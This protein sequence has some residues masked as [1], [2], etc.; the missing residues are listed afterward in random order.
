[1]LLKDWDRCCSTSNMQKKVVISTLTLK[2]AVMI[3]RYHHHFP[4]LGASGKDPNLAATAGCYIHIID[5]IC[6]NFRQR[7]TPL[8]C[9]R[10]HSMA[11]SRFRFFCRELVEKKSGI[12]IDLSLLIFQDIVYLNLT[13][14]VCTLLTYSF[15][16]TLFLCCYQLIRYKTKL[17]NQVS[18]VIFQKE[19]IQIWLSNFST[20]IKFLCDFCFYQFYHFDHYSER[21]MS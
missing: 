10:R 20:F 16:M 9:L 17:N 8:S 5:R 1:M 15:I 2:I 18:F 21:K 7:Y 4:Y 14:Y 19:I 13:T 11:N 6:D 3:D 12:R